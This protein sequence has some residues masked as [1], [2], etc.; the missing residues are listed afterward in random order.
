MNAAATASQSGSLALQGAQAAL[1]LSWWA[2]HSD[3]DIELRDDASSTS[4]ARLAYRTWVDA[5]VDIL[6]G[7]Y[8]SNLVRAVIPVMTGSGKLLWNHGGSTDDLAHTMVV[9][10]PAPA[11]TYL[12]GAVEI[13]AEMGTE[14]ILLAVGPGPVCRIRRLGHSSRG[15]PGRP[16]PQTN[17]T[18]ESAS[19]R[20][21]SDQGGGADHSQLRPG[22]SGHS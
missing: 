17:R 4:T 1:G 12:T 22:G 16:S 2:A 3:V 13:A 15:R 7:P 14:E 11:S 19:R 20:A 6:L 18:G 21:G 9:P 8:G 10:L 5:A